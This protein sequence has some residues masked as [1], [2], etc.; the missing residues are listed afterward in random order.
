MHAGPVDFVAGGA[1]GVTELAR[2]EP[3]QA[4]LIFVLLIGG[5]SVKAAIFPLHGWLPAAM[6]APAPVSA[7]LHAVAVVKAGVF[8]IVRVIDD[9]FGIEVA[10][11]LGV[12]GPLLAVACFT[13]LYGSYQA[14]R[15]TELKKRLAFSTVSQVSYVVL[16]VSMVSVLATAGGVV[17]LVHQLSLIHI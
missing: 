1:E 9:V 10:E 13:V 15:Q 14:M 11:E 2:Q 17:H 6:V 4:V 8:G 16:G 5:L 12:L 7:L 3:V